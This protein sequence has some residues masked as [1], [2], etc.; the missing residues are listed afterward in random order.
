VRSACSTHS[1][2]GSRCSFRALG[3]AAREISDDEARALARDWESRLN[4]GDISSRALLSALKV[5][6]AVNREIG[7]D[8]SI[9]GGINC[10]NESRFSD[11]TPVWP[12]TCSMKSGG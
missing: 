6:L 5:Y 4:I 8:P 10:L 2:S 9:V 3:Q 11:T 7:Q 1:A 12:G